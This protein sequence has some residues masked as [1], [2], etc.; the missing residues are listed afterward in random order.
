MTCVIWGLDPEGAK[1]LDL[2]NRKLD[3]S[4]KHI[5]RHLSRF[6]LKKLDVKAIQQRLAA[7][8]GPQKKVLARAAKQLGEIV[9]LH[10]GLLRERQEIEAGAASGGQ[11]TAFV[12]AEKALFPGVVVR[13][14]DSKREVKTPMKTSRFQLQG[15]VMAI[16]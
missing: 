5:V 1:K 16:R 4:N 9:Q 14:G 7:S 8:T 13:I 11:R 12:E 15:G 6:N 3:E 2:L 10:Q